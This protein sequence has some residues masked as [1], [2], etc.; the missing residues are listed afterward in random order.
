MNRMVRGMWNQVR[1]KKRYHVSISRFKGGP[2]DRRVG[3]T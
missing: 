3:V 2:Q 1:R